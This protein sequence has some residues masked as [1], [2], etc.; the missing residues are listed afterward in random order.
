[1]SLSL[2]IRLDTCSMPRFRNSSLPTTSVKCCS[3]GARSGSVWLTRSNSPF[4]TCYS[5]KRTCEA[6]GLREELRA[7]VQV[8]EGSYSQAVGRMELSAQE[9]AAG[10][11]HL[12]QLQQARGR[13]QRLSHT[14][15]HSGGHDCEKP[16]AEKQNEKTNTF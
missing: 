16:T 1:M 12:V 8:G 3:E 15:A 11:L 7:G 10:L 4:L 2:A 9:L 14:N 5:D 6:V 13:Q